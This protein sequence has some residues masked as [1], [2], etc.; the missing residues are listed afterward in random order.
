MERSEMRTGSTA[1]DT[2][3]GLRF[4][5]SGLL[6]LCRAVVRMPMAGHQMVVHHS[7]RLHEGVDDGR[8]D[9]LEATAG[10][11]LGDRTGERR[12]CRNVGEAAPMI[13]LRLAID[14]VP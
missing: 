2:V 6:F 4:A 11:F 8:P 13:Y 7:D 5:P 12:R 1:G 3:P 9:E 14:E 10:E